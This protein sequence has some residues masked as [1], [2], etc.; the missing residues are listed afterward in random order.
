MLKNLYTGLGQ[1]SWFLGKELLHQAPQDLTFDFLLP[2]NRF[3]LFANYPHLQDTYWL[4]RHGI[5]LIR[6]FLYPS[7]NLWHITSQHSRYFP[8]FSKS[9]VIYTIHDLNFLDEKSPEFARRKLAEI[10]QRIDQATAITAISQY[11]AEV[12]NK[13]LHLKGK[14]IEVIYN[15]VEVREF[16][17]AV[18]PQYIDNQ[19]FLFSIST[20]MEKKN[21]HSL[22]PFMSQIPDYQLIIAGRK[23]A[24]YT[25]KLENEIGKYGLENRVILAGEVSDEQKYWLYQNCEAFVF[26]SKLEGFGLPVIEAM[27][28]G[29]PVFCSDL[30]SLPEVGGKEAYYW[31]SFAPEAMKEVFLNGMADFKNTP[32]KA[33]ALKQYSQNFIWQ[34]AAQQYLELYHKILNFN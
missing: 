17:Q 9:P 13:N 14:K 5:D 4:R 1:F 31:Q 27:R 3:D 23:P 20:L 12:V 25:Q 29:K 34:R 26:P 16:P 22:I 28:L 32:T 30:T 24:E 11:T 6:R 18:R 2:K 7:Y 19:P 10:Q 8:F 21:F 15:G 33:E